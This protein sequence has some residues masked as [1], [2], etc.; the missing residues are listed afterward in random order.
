MRRKAH[1]NRNNPYGNRNVQSGDVS[2]LK[3][4]GYI[5]SLL[6]QDAGRTTQPPQKA[7]GEGAGKTAQGTAATG[8]SAA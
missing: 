4:I 2:F 6:S 8:S 3:A 1:F 7:T 5:Y